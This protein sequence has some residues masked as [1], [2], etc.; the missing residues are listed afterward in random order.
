MWA[1]KFPGETKECCC[2]DGKVKLPPHGES[3]R[4]LRLLFN[5]PV[6]MKSI[7]A[8]NNTS[9][10]TSI[11]GT[12][13][14]PLRV[15]E[16]VTMRGIYKSCVM[17]SWGIWVFAQI[18]IND[19]DSA[20]CVA[21]RIRTTDGMNAEFLSELDEVMEQYRDVHK[22]LID[23]EVNCE[24]RLHVG[25]GTNPG[26]HNTPTAF[27][28]AAIIF[29]AN[30]AQPQDIVLYTRQ[31]GFNR[32]N[33]SNPHYD[34]LHYP[35]LHPYGESGWTYKLPYATYLL[36]DRTGEH[37]LLRLGSRL[38]QQYCFDQ[39]SSAEQ[40]R[41][42]Y[43]ENYQLEFRLKTIQGLTVAHR[44]DDTEDHLVAVMYE[45]ERTAQDSVTDRERQQNTSNGTIDRTLTMLDG[46]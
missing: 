16:S 5:N 12:R 32:I 38:T 17:A 43:I 34:P 31:G 2:I 3:L 1:W 33:E 27:E 11:G 19:H 25:H 10:F 20:A 41:L 14:E 44:Q 23:P 29:D 4:K 36:Y 22:R 35:L 30:A 7:R 9:A 6:F 18:Y 37:S 24:L 21:S 28:V 40:Q 46:V 45:L 39:W 42:R 8:Y 26:T 13:S 15:D